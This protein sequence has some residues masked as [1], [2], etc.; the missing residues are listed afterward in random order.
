MQSIFLATKMSEKVHKSL[1]VA[2][3]KWQVASGKWQVAGAMWQLAVA[4]WRVASGSSAL[5]ACK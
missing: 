1:R 3:G 4:C 5:H 2:S